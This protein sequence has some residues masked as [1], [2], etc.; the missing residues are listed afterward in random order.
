MSVNRLVATGALTAVRVGHQ[1][2]FEQVEIDRYLGDNRTT[3]R[4]S[5]RRG[6]TSMPAPVPA[7]VHL[8]LTPVG[9]QCRPAMSLCRCPD[10]CTTVDSW[11]PIPL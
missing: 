10:G 9:H 4:A 8:S 3:R 1:Y 2:R 11:R 7:R 6:G 5:W